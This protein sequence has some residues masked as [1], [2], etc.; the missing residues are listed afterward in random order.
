[1]KVL[2]VDDSKAVQRSF[3]N[4][5]ASMPH[6]D[7]VGCADDVAGALAMI[8]A[9]TPD[10]IVLD[11]EL[12]HGERGMDVLKH[13]MQMRPTTQVVVLSNFT[14]QAMRNTLLAAGAAAYFDKS[15]EFTLARDWIAQRAAAWAA[16]GQAA[17]P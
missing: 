9:W 14:W 12:Q 1:M 3:G 6:V 10:L 4:L 15:N 5:L 11:I 16:Q 17:P 7:L 13:V 2:V 8:E